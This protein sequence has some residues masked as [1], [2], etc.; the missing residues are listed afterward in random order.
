MINSKK[1][2]LEYTVINQ[3]LKNKPRIMTAAREKRCAT[4]KKSTTGLIA[5]FSSETMEAR[6]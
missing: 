4:F 5:D 6:R 2:T 1:S 3:V